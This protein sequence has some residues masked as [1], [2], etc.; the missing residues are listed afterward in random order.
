MKKLTHPWALVSQIIVLI[1]IIAALFPGIFAHGNPL[2]GEFEPL[3]SPSLEHWF[4]TDSIG[5]DLYTRVV[6]GTRQSLLGGLIAVLVGATFGTFIGLIAGVGGKFVDTLLMRAID[7]LL[8]IPSLLLSLSI[9]VLLGYGTI[10]AA[11]AVGLTS[12]AAFA[13]L[14]R[15]QVLSV[16]QREFVEAAYGS[17]A[18]KAQVIIRHILPN[19][20]SPVLALAAVQFGSAILQLSVLGFLGYGAPPPTPEWGLIIS[21]ARDYLATSWW[22]TV[23]PGVVIISV[24]VAANY[25]SNLV[26]KERN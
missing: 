11:I 5:R 2:S 25:L 16:A 3:L 12:V 14:A 17:G 21:D 9:I 19:S 20:L 4:G 15:S 1:A 6:Y 10:N 18:T 24:V 26:A 7:V 23:L 8:A 22:L 13:R